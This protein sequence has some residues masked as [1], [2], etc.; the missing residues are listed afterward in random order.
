MSGSR[1]LRKECQRENAHLVQAGMLRTWLVIQ[2]A[3]TGAKERL[4]S[5]CE[6]ELKTAGRPNADQRVA[7][8]LLS[9]HGS[10]HSLWRGRGLLQPGKLAMMPELKKPQATGPS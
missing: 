4:H 8:R 2:I 5:L 10:Q 1:E 3:T 6:V 9:P 7:A